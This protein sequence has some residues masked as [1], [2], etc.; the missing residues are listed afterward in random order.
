MFLTYIYIAELKTD[1]QATDLLVFL[2]N[3]ATYAY[4]SPIY[5]LGSRKVLLRL[6]K[7]QEIW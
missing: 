3:W 6:L 4:N 5:N 2:F 1:V 7:L